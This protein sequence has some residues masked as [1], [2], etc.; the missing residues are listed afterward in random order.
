[1]GQEFVNKSNTFIDVRDFEQGIPKV[2]CLQVPDGAEYVK[3][4]NIMTTLNVFIAKRPMISAKSGIKKLNVEFN[5][6]PF[7]TLEILNTEFISNPTR[8]CPQ[9]IKFNDQES[10]ALI[11]FTTVRT[12]QD[13][14]FNFRL[15]RPVEYGGQSESLFAD[16]MY[17]YDTDKYKKE[18]HQQV[19]EKVSELESFTPELAELQVDHLTVV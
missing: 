12:F 15:G 7:G 19:P 14:L 2:S 18:M 11:K 3:F 16:E 9:S 4:W 5:I 17:S 10:L 13:L 1:M 8:N 6:S